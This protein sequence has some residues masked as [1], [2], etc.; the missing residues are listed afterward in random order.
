MFIQTNAISPEQRVDDMNSS[1]RLFFRVLMVISCSSALSNCVIT[2]QKTLANTEVPEVRPGL[3]TGY[4]SKQALPNSLSIIPAPPVQNSE[5]ALRDI[6][7]NEDAIALRDTRQWQRATRDAQLDYPSVLNVFRCELGFKLG[8]ST[9]HLITLLRRSM[10]DA[11]SSTILAK[12]THLRERPFVAT[13]QAICTP[14]ERLALLK[15]GSYPSGHAAMGMTWALILSNLVPERQNA[16]LQR[17]REF[18]DHRVICGV[19]WQSD[20]DMGRLMGQATYA[21]LVDNPEFRAQLNAA[22]QE[23][24]TQL[25]LAVV[26]TDQC[27]SSQK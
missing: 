7:V 5:I 11:G 18:G 24:N 21:A 9:P 10:V 3:L 13:L 22:K 26:N 16:L 27:V 23:I 8:D 20:V 15:S 17:G 6:Q 14:D 4:L 19:H 1:W 25:K 2:P 12:Q